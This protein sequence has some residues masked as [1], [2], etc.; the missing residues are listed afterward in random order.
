MSKEKLA[1]LVDSVEELESL[2]NE[3]TNKQ[4]ERGGKQKLLQRLATR[5]HRPLGN[6]LLVVIFPQFFEVDQ[7]L[8]PPQQTP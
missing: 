1:A 5:M 3:N 8:L 4:P 6:Q 2:E 7:V